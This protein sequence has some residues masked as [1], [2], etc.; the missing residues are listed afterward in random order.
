MSLM[1]QRT[2]QCEGKKSPTLAKYCAACSIAVL[3]V[4]VFVLVFRGLI[5]APLDIADTMPTTAQPT[6]CRKTCTAFPVPWEDF[7]AFREKIA[8]C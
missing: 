8:Y 4:M 1:I 3:I 5:T 7:A 2:S 6:K